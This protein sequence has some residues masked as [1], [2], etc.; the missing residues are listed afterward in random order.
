MLRPNDDPAATLDRGALEALYARLEKPVFNVAY[1]WLWNRD[2]ALEVTQEAFLR[3][4]NM[5]T[6]VDMTTVEPLVFRIA[7][8]LAARRRRS[9]RLWGWLSM[10]AAA[11]RP[12]PEAGADERLAERQAEATVRAAIEALPEKLKRVV[13]LLELSGLGHAEVAR[14]L[15]IPMGTVASRKHAA[16]RQLEGSL[17][18]LGEVA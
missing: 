17:G 4:W 2:D 18:R 9:R 14:T 6:R 16:M 1:R 12:A 15:G 13:V 10:E 3:L 7:L 11:D 5:R 8:N